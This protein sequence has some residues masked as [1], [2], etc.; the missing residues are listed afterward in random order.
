MKYLRKV[1][2]AAVGESVEAK[3]Q[4][5]DWGTRLPAI[6][7]F[8]TAI[9]WDDGT[10]RLRGSLILFSEEG[11]WKLCLSDKDSGRVAFVTAQ[12]PVEVFGAAEKGLAAGSLDWR[13]SKSAGGRG[14]RN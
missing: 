5:G 1:V 9:V 12:T 3:A 11:L 14:R 13:A 4:A 7:E 6:T 8:L 2:P 10:P